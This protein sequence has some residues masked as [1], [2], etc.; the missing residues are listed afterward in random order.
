MSV[1]MFATILPRVPFQGGY[2]QATKSVRGKTWRVSAWIEH[3][4]PSGR[5]YHTLAHTRVRRS[6]EA[7]LKA[8]TEMAIFW[9][10]A[11]PEVQ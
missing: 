1:H 4:L 2:V 6:Q 7:A 11:N 5:E 9:S 3:R 10:R 8:A